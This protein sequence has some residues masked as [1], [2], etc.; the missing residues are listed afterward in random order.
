[1]RS[2]SFEHAREPV[3]SHSKEHDKP[4]SNTSSHGSP[5][6]VTPFPCLICH[7]HPPSSKHWHS[8]SSDHHFCPLYFFS[9]CCCC[10]FPPNLSSSPPD[11]HNLM[12]PPVYPDSP[13]PD[14][15]SSANVSL[16]VPLRVAPFDIPLMKETKDDSSAINDCCSQNTHSLNFSTPLESGEIC[17]SS[18]EHVNTSFTSSTG[19]TD[20]SLPFN[21]EVNSA[22]YIVSSIAE[23][24]VFN[25]SMNIIDQKLENR[26]DKSSSCSM[27]I[28][29]DTKNQVDTDLKTFLLPLTELQSTP[30]SASIFSPNELIPPAPEKLFRS[31]SCSENLIASRIHENDVISSCK[32]PVS[33]VGKPSQPPVCANDTFLPPPNIFDVLQNAR[34]S[35]E[36]YFSH[37]EDP[38]LNLVSNPSCSNSTVKSFDCAAAL[39]SDI[40]SLNDS[41]QNVSTSFKPPLPSSS[42]SSF[43]NPPQRTS[44][45]SPHFTSSY[46]PFHCHC[47][48][49][50]I[51]FLDPANRSCHKGHSVIHKDWLT[52]NL[53]PLHYHSSPASPASPEGSDGENCLFD[54]SGMGE[55]VEKGKGEVSQSPGAVLPSHP[56]ISSPEV[57]APP[58]GAGPQSSS[59]QI[60]PSSSTAAQGEASHSKHHHHHHHQHHHRHSVSG[61]L[62]YFRL[63]P[64]GGVGGALQFLHHHFRGMAAGFGGP[65]AGRLFSTA[66]ISGSSSAPNLSDMIPNVG[67]SVSAIEGCGGVPPIRPLETLHNALSLRQLDTFLQ[68]MTATHLFRT[69]PLSSPPHDPAPPLPIG[70]L[71]PLS[72][73]V[74][75]TSSSQSASN[76]SS[77]GHTSKDVREVVSGAHPPPLR[78]QSPSNSIGWSGPPSFVSSSSGPS[79]PN[80]CSS[81]SSLDL[82]LFSASARNAGMPS[83]AAIGR[84]LSSECLPQLSVESQQI[85][86]PGSGPPI[87]SLLSSGTSTISTSSNAVV[88]HERMTYV[89]TLSSTPTIDSSLVIGGS[90]FS[91]YTPSGY[92]SSTTTPSTPSYV[93]GSV[94]SGRM[95]HLGAASPSETTTTF[96]VSYSSCQSCSKQNSS[97]VVSP[98]SVAVASRSL[99]PS[100]A[101]VEM[102]DVEDLGSAGILLD[103]G[104][105]S[106]LISPEGSS[107]PP[108]GTAEEILGEEEDYEEAEEA[109][110]LDLTVVEEVSEAVVVYEEVSSEISL[111]KSNN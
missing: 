15:I 93:A 109:E 26:M 87:S 14:S 44:F 69:T 6:S 54:E 101:S 74:A 52:L 27:S 4:P 72:Q 89:R 57:P 61:Q 39:D 84:R 88:C 111:S 64:L 28:P 43:H 3:A 92:M 41:S 53:L 106:E 105:Q 16:P 8:L 19:N 9:H 11:E 47:P 38:L 33:T 102:G 107:T 108:S 56:D 96:S 100:G 104:D 13:S 1:M 90:N 94:S 110:D 82:Y 95:V 32:V 65:G 7:S 22:T 49:Q 80:G 81:S 58:L 42:M 2:R 78:L 34:S 29:E 70:S 35:E 55:V 30:L 46:C 103:A 25:Q 21:K 77:G 50:R 85:S 40:K 23:N 31:L 60:P 91:A 71:P 83:S 59:R 45:F 12:P 63:L 37:S 79:S 48:C 24:T 18:T 51:N 36:N 20:K 98:S 97:E 5:P 10:C 67:G 66:V 68:A 76:V 99:M 73:G 62:G 75:S 86:Q 17:S